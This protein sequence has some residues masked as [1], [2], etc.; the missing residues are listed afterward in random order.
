MKVTHK[1]N[2]AFSAAGLLLVGII[3]FLFTIKTNIIILLVLVPIVAGLIGYYVSM[4]LS[5]PFRELYKRTEAMRSGELEY[6]IDMESEDEVGQLSKAFDTM[7]DDIKKMSESMD[8]LNKENAS[9][10]N[11]IKDLHENEEHFHNLFK[12]SND[13]VFIYDFEDKIIDANKRACDMLGYPKEVLLKKPF[14]EL[15]DKEELTKSKKAYKNNADT[16]SFVF[17]SKF[18]KS[19]GTPIDVQISSG[20]VDLKKGIMQAIVQNISE[21]KELEVKLVDSEEKFRSFMETASDLMFI[22]DK[23]GHFLYVNEA[24]ANKLGYS[25]EELFGMHISEIMTRKSIED[26]KVKRQQLISM[27]EAAYEPVWETKTRK[28]VY[29]ELG[30]VAI[31]DKSGNYRGSR[32][33]FRDITERKKVEE[34][35]RLANLGKLAANVA[36]EVNNPVTVISG[37]AELALMEE[38]LPADLKK[39]LE[40]IVDQC[41]QARS[42]VKRLLMFSK[43]SKGR[44]AEANIN[45]SVDV[46]I[47]L[48]ES[49]FKHSRVRIK[50]NSD[51]I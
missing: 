5:S 35:Q 21:R 6:R 48:V 26:Y 24:M 29:G 27:G 31:Y 20:I 17:E 49:Q 41:E 23:D 4:V 10:K 38:S 37:N 44:F 1:I 13:A 2:I 51:H 46:V 8:S 43:P 11:T 19:D 9:Q 47:S 28:Q 16:C 40:V 7:A 22:S 25:K 34:S 15:Y 32:G 3:L 18:V 14:L 39:S 30:E 12:N 33:V 36:H 42:I 45:N 50:K